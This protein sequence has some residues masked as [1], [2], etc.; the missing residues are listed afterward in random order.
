MGTIGRVG[1]AYDAE[2]DIYQTLAKLAINPAI[3][4]EV[5]HS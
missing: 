1:T 3:S 2:A 5:S 4:N